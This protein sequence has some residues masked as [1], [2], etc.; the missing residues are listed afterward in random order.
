M[1]EGFENGT[2]Q[3]YG[4]PQQ[5]NN[6]SGMAI[7]S[8]ILGIVAIVVVCIRF[9]IGMIISIVSAIVA[10]VLGVMHNKRN[11]KSGM[12]I[13]GIVCGIVALVLAVIL[14]VLMV[15][16]LLALG[17]ALGALSSYGL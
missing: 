16:G 8:M 7:A 13:A 4:E 2:P 6:S 17:G 10:I 11:S 5:N 14:V 3:Y 12:A 15:I 9:P 1:S